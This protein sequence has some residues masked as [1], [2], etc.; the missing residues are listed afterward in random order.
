MGMEH[1]EIHELLSRLGT[2]RNYKGFSQ[3]VCAVELCREDP[4]R[5]E[6]ATKWVCPAVAARCGTS[7]GAVERNIRT[8]RGVIW[9]RNRPLLEELARVPLLEMPRP[10]QL[11]SILASSPCPG[12][13]AVHG[14]GKV[15]ALARKDHDV[16]VVDQPVDESGGESVVAEDGVP[17]AELQVGGDDG[18]AAF[19]AV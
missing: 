3:A 19:V 11:L 16:G 17:L 9:M 14:L 6:L 18:A 13:L 7:W 1:P 10:A 2:T 12:P 5:L 4:E 15:V 8:V